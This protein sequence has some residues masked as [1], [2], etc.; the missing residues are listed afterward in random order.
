[1]P[2]QSQN[3]VFSCATGCATKAHEG[4]GDLFCRLGRSFA[5]RSPEIMQLPADK[6]EFISGSETIGQSAESAR[7]KSPGR[8]PMLLYTSCRGKDLEK[9]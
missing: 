7:Q 3:P 6:C 4:I 1:M 5:Q 2:T 9:F 8:T